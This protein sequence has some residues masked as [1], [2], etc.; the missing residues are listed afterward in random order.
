MAVLVDT[1]S[2][3]RRL[4]REGSRLA[5]WTSLRWVGRDPEASRSRSVSTEELI[6]P[7]E[8][9]EEGVGASL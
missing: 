9:P 7:E 5:G 2:P 6:A 8:E 1:T 3:R 4:P